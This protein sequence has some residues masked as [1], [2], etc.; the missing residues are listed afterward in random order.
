MTIEKAIEMIQNLRKC[1]LESI[2]IMIGVGSIENKIQLICK[3]K[4]DY[5][6]KI[7]HEIEPKIF[8]CEHPKKLRDIDPDGIIYCMICNQ[9]L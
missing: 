3:G 4:A 8:P 9:N 1:E 2:K 5:L 7:L 6:G